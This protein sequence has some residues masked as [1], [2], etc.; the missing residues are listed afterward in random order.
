MIREATEYLSGRSI[1]RREP[2]YSARRFARFVADIPA[3][4]VRAEHLDQLRLVMQSRGYRARTI[5]TTVADIL[6]VI[7]GVTGQS[8][9][10]GRR[11]PVPRPEPKPVPLSSI[12]AIWPHCAP[13]L[14]SWIAV[15][16]W[17]GLRVSDSLRVC[18]MP[19]PPECLRFQASKT[20]RNHVWPIPEWLRQWWPEFFPLPKATDFNLRLL[21]KSIAD[22]CTAA[23]VPH[24]H[25]Q[26]LRQRS[27]TEWS[28][29]N[30]TAGAI[31]HGCGLGVLAHY[32]DPLSVLEA[33]A[34]RV[35]VPV[36]MLGSYQ[37]ASEDSLL[38]AWR[39]CDPQAREL[40][41]AT[42]ERMASAG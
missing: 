14:R 13:W 22:A 19:A 24:W 38:S 4:N 31:V 3:A 15:T 29:A 18:N 28:R 40:V 41:T 6:T 37:P 27:I 33:A 32:V 26:Q 20:G 42:A 17:T 8:P 12:D 25:P 10:R 2:L 7:H 11:I 21:R 5:E 35:R 39:R 16:Y 34:P 30:A 9:G 36:A 23:S 1:V